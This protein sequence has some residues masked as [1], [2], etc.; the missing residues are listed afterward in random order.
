MKQAMYGF[1]Q[2][3]PSNSLQSVP[4]L[5]PHSKSIYLLPE[6]GPRVSATVLF[7]NVC[8]R[9]CQQWQWLLPVS[10]AL[11]CLKIIWA[12]EF[13][14][15]VPHIPWKTIAQAQ[16]LGKL[17]NITIQQLKTHFLCTCQHL[18]TSGKAPETPRKATTFLWSYW[19]C[20]S[21]EQ[22]WKMGNEL[23]T[24]LDNE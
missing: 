8:C 16:G 7:A 4:I 6:H 22:W 12:G 5:L 23:P 17:H 18:S 9:H 21:M 10:V 24:V 2:V 11:S 3:P 13:V 19:C 20:M 1:W 14:Q 15:Q